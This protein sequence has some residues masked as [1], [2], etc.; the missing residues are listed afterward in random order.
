MGMKFA[1]KFIGT[2]VVKSQLF[3]LV[4]GMLSITGPANTQKDGFESFCTYKFAETCMLPLCRLQLLSRLRVFTAFGLNQL[5]VHMSLN[6]IL[7]VRLSHTVRC[8]DPL[9]KKKK[10]MMMK[11][12]KEKKKQ[13]V[14]HDGGD[15]EVVH[16]SL[17]PGTIKRTLV[18]WI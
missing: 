13:G 1:S 8:A 2:L 12:K 7:L 10:M 11:K 6:C 4:K 17:G 9:K 18:P 15:L 14:W 3:E 16:P 5:E